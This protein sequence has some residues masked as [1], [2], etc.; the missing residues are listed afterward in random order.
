MSHVTSIL[1]VHHIEQTVRERL[2]VCYAALMISSWR[3]AIGLLLAAYASAT[4]VAASESAGHSP[5][6]DGSTRPSA[7]STAS[8]K[9]EVHFIDVGQGDSILILSPEGRAVL[10]DAGPRAGGEI[11]LNL[12]RGKG[13]ETLDLVVATHAHL[14]HIGGLERIL[15]TIPTRYYMDPGYPHGSRAYHRL[16]ETLEEL[17]IPVLTGR[18]GRRVNLG[19]GSVMEIVAP[20]EPLHSGTRSDVN[21]NSIVAHVTHGDVS[22]LLTGDAEKQTERYLVTKGNITAQVLKVAHHGSRHSSTN[23]FLEMVAPE[24]AVIQVGENNQYGHPTS[25]TL[26]RLESVNARVYRTDVH[27][28]ITIVSDGAGYTVTTERDP[29]ED[30]SAR[31]EIHT[32]P[33]EYKACRALPRTI[34]SATVNCLASSTTCN[35]R[36]RHPSPAHRLTSSNEE[37]QNCL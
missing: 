26:E 10:I 15:K 22:I 4:S 27:G 18:A 17:E 31:N 30:E 5:N 25:E 28:T 34:E 29:G 9:L 7:T 20:S 33:A 32:R 12:L 16:L 13:I 21:S 35:D 19:G 3:I 1:P 2:G 8:K 37:E 6:D 11:V 36:M 14:D 23:P 24:V